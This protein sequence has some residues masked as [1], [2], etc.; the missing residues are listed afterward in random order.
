LIIDGAIGEVRQ[1]R[2][3]FL[4]DWLMDPARWIGW[5]L[6]AEA[7]GGVLLDLGAH[8]VDLIHYLI[9]PIARVAAVDKRFRSRHSVDD[10][11]SHGEVEDA[12]EAVLVTHTGAIGTL[13]LSRVADG[14]R[15]QNGFEIVASRGSLRWEFQRMNELDVY[16]ADGP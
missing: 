15:S 10:G 5:R 11:P 16:L 14:Y 7:G 8:L 3:H 1:F 4:Q 2:L 13:T 6:S 9:G 12:F